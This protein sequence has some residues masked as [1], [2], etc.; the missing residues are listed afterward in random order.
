MRRRSLPF[1]QPQFQQREPVVAALRRR[2]QRLVAERPDVL[3]VLLFGSFARGDFGRRSDADLLIVLRQSSAPP[4]ARAAE[5]LR[6]FLETPVPVDCLVLT[7]AE[8]R[9]MATEGRPFWR[10]LRQEAVVLAEA[11]GASGEPEAG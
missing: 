11:P 2:A 4:H 5:F 3:R 8:V 9:A 7:E 10:R 6:A 1:V